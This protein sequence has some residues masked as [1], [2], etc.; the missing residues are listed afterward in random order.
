MSDLT[1]QN[2]LFKEL[3]SVMRNSLLIQNMN[4]A[5]KKLIA[6]KYLD[7]PPEDIAM[8]I[9]QIKN[10]DEQFRKINEENE[11]EATKAAEKLQQAVWEAE[12][13]IRLSKKEKEDRDREHEKADLDSIINKLNT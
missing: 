1:N 7:A 2:E 10:D 6:D 13:Y 4:D 5:D 3:L 11:I 8:A 9:Q 12:K